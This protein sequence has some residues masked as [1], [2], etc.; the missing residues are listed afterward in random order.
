MRHIGCF[1]V[2]LSC[3]GGFPLCIFFINVSVS[4]L[5]WHIHHIVPFPV[6]FLKHLFGIYSYISV[7]S[8]EAPVS[9]YVV[10]YGIIGREYFPHRYFYVVCYY[11]ISCYLEVSTFPVAWWVLSVVFWNRVG[12]SFLCYSYTF[13]S[14]ISNHVFI[15]DG[16]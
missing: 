8:F 2:L 7:C 16:S 14:S 3:F 10:E 11:L 13:K 5:S 1:Y 6:V 9:H 15:I 12:T 4:S